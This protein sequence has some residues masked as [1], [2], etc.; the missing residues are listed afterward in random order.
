MK[1]LTAKLLCQRMNHG[2]HRSSAFSV[3]TAL[4]S[5]DA[6]RCLGAVLP[7]LRNCFLEMKASKTD[8]ESQTSQTASW[9]HLDTEHTEHLPIACKFTM[10]WPTS[11]TASTPEGSHWKQTY[12]VSGEPLALQEGKMEWFELHCGSPASPPFSWTFAL[13]PTPS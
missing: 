9:G 2:L 6:L 8:P 3:S 11:S 1:R 7:W 4:D 10:Q 5:L 12:F 13:D